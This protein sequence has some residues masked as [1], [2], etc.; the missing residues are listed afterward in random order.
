MSEIDRRRI[1]AVRHL[2]AAGYRFKAGEWHPPAS[3]ERRPYLKRRLRGRPYQ[4]RTVEDAFI[5]RCI[6]REAALRDG[7]ATANQGFHCIPQLLVGCWLREKWHVFARS[8]HGPDPAVKQ[9]GNA[10]FCEMCAQACA[11]TVWQ[12]VIEHGS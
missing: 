5:E 11:V 1:A 8:V 9:D 2:E 4:E 7:R 10:A 3:I 6:A 12:P